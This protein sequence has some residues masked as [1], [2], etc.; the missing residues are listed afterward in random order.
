MTIAK[1]NEFDWW[2]SDFGIDP[3]KLGCLMLNV[4]NPWHKP[5][6]HMP[7]PYNLPEGS[8]HSHLQAHEYKSD[9]LSYV[10]GLLTDWHLTARYGFLPEVKKKHVETIVERVDTPNYLNVKKIDVWESVNGEDYECVVAKIETGEGSIL[11]ELWQSLGVLPNIST[12]PYEP[13]ITLGYFHSGTWQN[14]F[15]EAVLK[16]LDVD[17]ANEWTYSKNLG[18]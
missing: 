18:E 6:L 10:D 2:M 3:N 16:I 5:M 11:N 9:K 8:L 15:S 13:H 7:L 17:Y 4:R 14:Q 1:A 12:F